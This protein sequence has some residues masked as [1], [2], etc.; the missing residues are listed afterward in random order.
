MSKTISTLILGVCSIFISTSVFG[1]ELGSNLKPIAFGA[2]QTIVDFTKVAWEPLDVEGLDPGA[3]IAVIRGNLEKSG[4]EVILKVPG[5][6]QVPMHSHTS[7]ETYI[8][9]KGA[10]TLVSENG[11]EH[12]FAGPS[13]V[14]FPGNAPKHALTCDDANGC[15]LYIRYSRPFDVIYQDRRVVAQKTK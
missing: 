11:R 12:S 1:H 5:G 14:S 4:S 10:Y 13:Y 2:D 9:L 8:W 15:L 3:H 7:D 6:Y